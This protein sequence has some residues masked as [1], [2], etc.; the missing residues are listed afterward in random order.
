MAANKA[1]TKLNIPFQSTGNMWHA[2]YG[3]YADDK[4]I[5]A[6]LL[7]AEL[8]TTINGKDSQMQGDP[9]AGRSF[10]LHTDNRVK[11][12]VNTSVVTE[13]I[14]GKLNIMTAFPELT[15]N[16]TIRAKLLE[17]CEYDSGFE[18]RLTLLV[19]APNFI[20]EEL[21][22]LWVFDTRYLI[23]KEKY[24]IGKHYDFHIGA[25]VTNIIHRPENELELEMNNELKEAFKKKFKEMGE[26]VFDIDD[27]KIHT[28][29]AFSYRPKYDDNPEVF[30]LRAQFSGLLGKELHYP[31]LPKKQVS[32]IFHAT[33]LH[34]GIKS[35]QLY[36]LPAY[37]TD[38]V[39]SDTNKH[40]GKKD[41]PL[42]F[43]EGD[44]VNIQGV[45]QGYLA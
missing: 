27:A 1:I 29:E 16:E 6:D 33:F 43:A 39:I 38:I 9:K 40:L 23:N 17:V 26:N 31:L 13:V 24:C 19:N 14:D 8:T 20:P 10:L 11:G 34:D 4:E 5:W 30:S 25:L 21:R 45:L 37:M 18:A 35:G 7:S 2:I 28:G 15:L 3:H 42:Q 36:S 12:Y 32:Y 22:L 41:L 44:P